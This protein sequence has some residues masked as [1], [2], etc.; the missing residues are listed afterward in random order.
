MTSLQNQRSHVQDEEL[1]E[2]PL[3]APS[4]AAPLAERKL[5]KSERGV[6]SR[7]GVAKE[8]TDELAGLK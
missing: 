4:V 8:L 7:A 3:T 5:I 6:Q 1:R 2:R